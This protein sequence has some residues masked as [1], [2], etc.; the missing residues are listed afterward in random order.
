REG[1]LV[2]HLD[3]SGPAA[4]AGLLKGDLLTKA[5]GEELSRAADLHRVLSSATPGDQ[6]ELEIVRGADERQIKVALGTEPER[7]E[8]EMHGRRHHRQR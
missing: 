7:P 5:N 8:G 1:V 4:Q 2:Q 3:D 6:L